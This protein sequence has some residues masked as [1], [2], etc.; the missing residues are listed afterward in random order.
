LRVLKAST[1][2][3]ALV[4]AAGFLLGI[5]RVG[6]L[7]PRTGTRIA[8]LAEEPIMLIVVVLAARL[9]SRRFLQDAGA[10]ARLATGCIALGLL[11]AAE[12]ITTRLRGISLTDYLAGRDPVSGTV[13]LVLLVIFAVMPVLIRAGD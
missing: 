2:Y 4:F 13:Y 12:L 8:E 1:A 5:I 6:W 10:T 9:V 11:V 7:T 3:F